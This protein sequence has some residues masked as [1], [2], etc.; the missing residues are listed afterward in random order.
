MLLVG[1]VD[2][3]NKTLEAEGVTEPIKIFFDL[4]RRLR[5]RTQLRI[6]YFGFHSGVFKDHD[7]YTSGDY[8]LLPGDNAPALFRNTP[9]EVR[10]SFRSQGEDIMS[11]NNEGILKLDKQSDLVVLPIEQ[12]LNFIPFHRS[13][14]A[15]VLFADTNSVPKQ[16]KNNGTLDG[17][18]AVAFCGHDELTN[19]HV[20]DVDEGRDQIEVIFDVI[21]AQRV[22]LNPGHETYMSTDPNIRMDSLTIMLELGSE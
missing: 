19:L 18:P 7:M 16:K 17:N 11:Y 20:G 21:G 12:G 9:S 22:R 5:K 3:E 1:K 13:K 2:I 8:T 6:K 15:E 14:M 4:P 10:V